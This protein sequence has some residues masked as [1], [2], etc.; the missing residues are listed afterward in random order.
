M[1]EGSWLKTRLERRAEI[2]RDLVRRSKGMFGPQSCPVW[3]IE[4]L[5][6]RVALTGC[7][8]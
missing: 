1:S 6:L 7:C 5:E 3:M 8:S 4:V 2:V